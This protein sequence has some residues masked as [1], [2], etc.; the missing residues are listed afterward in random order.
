MR[1]RLV[2]GGD[3]MNELLKANAVEKIEAYTFVVA[4]FSVGQQPVHLFLA[5]TSLLAALCCVLGQ[6]HDKH[7]RQKH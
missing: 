2:N 3:F 4:D 5:D 6:K 1:Q 7:L